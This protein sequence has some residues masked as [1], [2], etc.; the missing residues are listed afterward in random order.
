M[1]KKREN[2]MGNRQFSFIIFILYLLIL[3]YF[4]FLSEEMGRKACQEYKYNFVPFKEI[5]RYFNRY[6]VFGF[7]RVFLNIAGNILAFIPLG[8]FIPKIGNMKEKVLR[9][10]FFL[11]IFFVCLIEGIQLLTKVGS[12]DI[13]DVLLNGIGVVT[14]GIFYLLFLKEK[15]KKSEG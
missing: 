15:R 11:G 10:T 13:D 8:F 3:G 1:R 2:A 5:M 6:K 14:G 4:L 7:W 12:C 9:K